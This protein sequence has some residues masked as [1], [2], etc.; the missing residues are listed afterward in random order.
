M[1][2]LYLKIN[3]FILLSVFFTTSIFA[4]EKIDVEK[5]SKKFISDVEKITEELT[6]EEKS[7]AR[8]SFKNTFTSL[9]YSWIGELDIDKAAKKLKDDEYDMAVEKAANLAKNPGAQGVL[10]LGKAGEKIL[11]ALANTT[12]KVYKAGK[13]WV[14]ENAE[15]FDEKRSE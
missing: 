8:F 14:N 6:E 12:E 5:S 10:K 1:K 15:E 11:K 4:A 9:G 3:L 7:I 13:K 2:N